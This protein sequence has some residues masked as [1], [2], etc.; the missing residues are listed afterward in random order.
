MRALLVLNRVEACGVGVIVNLHTT[1]LRKRV[2]S[3]LSQNRKKEAFDLIVSEAMV[4]TYIPAGIEPHI[5]PELTL[6][7]EFTP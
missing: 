2:L 7:E 6:V 5:K 3:F 4:E 1:S